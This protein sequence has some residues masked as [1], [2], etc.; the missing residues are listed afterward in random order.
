MRTKLL[1]AMILVATP[2]VAQDYTSRWGF[3][4]WKHRDTVGTFYTAEGDS[5]LYTGIIKKQFLNTFS[6]RSEAFW[7]KF[8]SR[9]SSSLHAINYIQMGN[10]GM[11]SGASG[12]DIG[13]NRP[14]DISVT[15]VTWALAGINPGVGEGLNGQAGGSA[16][17]VE[18]FSSTGYGVWAHGVNYGG[19]FNAS[20]NGGR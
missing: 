14:V 9:D 3:P 8:H 18:G 2:L 20:R 12:T 16:A 19:Y 10:G 4:L 15:T 5:N 6:T 1:G 17:G 13:I 7:S 11:I